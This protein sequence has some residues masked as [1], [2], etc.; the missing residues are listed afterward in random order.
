MPVEPNEATYVIDADAAARR[1]TPRTRAIVPVHLYGLPV[2]MA[3]FRALASKHGLFL[4]EDA[5][6]AHGA[7]N[8]SV[9]VGAGP[10]DAAAWSF[11]PGKN[12]GAFGDGGALTTNDDQLAERFRRLR[13]Y[14]SSVKYV[15]DDLG[16]NTRL[17]PVQ[18]AVLSVKLTRLTEWNAR[19]AA[20]ATAYL[21]GLRGVPGLTLPVVPETDRHAWH[22]FVVQS[23][24]RDELREAL[25]AQGVQTLIHYPIAPHRQ[26]AYA[27]AMRGE[28]LPVADRLHARVLSLPIGPHLTEAQQQHVI[29]SVRE[30]A[31]RLA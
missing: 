21:E 26:G 7:A 18:A 1:I 13:N 9:R 27:A 29:A 5:A 25:A 10:S 24:R 8:G 28:V 11:Y 22:L 30:S 12:L 4:L 14:G 2:D 20:V 31:R 6:Q 19:R 16:W 23:A 15:H 17:D 3:P